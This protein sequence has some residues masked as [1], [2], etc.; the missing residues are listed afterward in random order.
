MS[1]L[2]YQ[3]CVGAGGSRAKY[4]LFIFA[5]LVSTFGTVSAQVGGGTD[6]TG[7]GGGHT[8][9]GRI[10]F[11]SGRTADMRAK[12][13]L[14]NTNSGPLSVLADLD[15]AFRFTNLGAGSYT[16]VIDAGK[17][18]ETVRESVYIEGNS[19]LGRGMRVPTLTRVVTVPIFLQVKRER[20][21]STA[22]GLL[23]AALAGVPKPAVELYHTAI[24]A[25]R[26]GD[27]KKAIAQLKSAIY[28]YPTFALALNELGVQYLK[29]GQADK[30]AEALESAVKITP[31]ELIPR[32]NYGIALLNQ[33]RFGESEDQLRRAL[34]KT[35]NAPTAHM[36]LGIALAMQRKLPEAEKELLTAIDSKSNEVAMAHRYLGGVYIDKREYK[37]AADALEKYLEQTPKASD[38]ERIRATIKELRSKGA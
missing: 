28:L 33:R 37:L 32:L 25:S 6:S 17:E 34:S 23:N 31:D 18:Y 1:S 7:T 16:I 13:N 10:Y 24:E 4:V 11:P 9:Q 19:S 5:A 20:R 15:G 38:T 12:V 30:A 26:T 22:P 29:L 8:I 14:E 35:T 3:E 27:N 2:A 21:N 36:Y